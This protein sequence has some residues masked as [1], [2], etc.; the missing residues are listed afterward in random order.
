MAWRAACDRAEAGRTARPVELAKQLAERRQAQTEEEIRS[1]TEAFRDN[2][3]A[4]RQSNHGKAQDGGTNKE[5]PEVPVNGKRSQTPVPPMLPRVLVDPQ[6]LELINPEG[7][8][9]EGSDGGGGGKAKGKKLMEPSKKGKSPSNRVSYR[10]YTDLDRETV[11][12]DLFK[13]LFGSDREDMTDLRTQRG[14]GADAID[15]LRRF[16]ELKVHAGAEPD[17][18]KLT[19]AEV[20]RALSTDD[21]FLVVVSDVEGADAVPRSE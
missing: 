16:F 7:R 3:A 5:L 17:Q 19:N 11:G 4:R 20:R 12:M 18:V 21:Y 14:V 6:D 2:T 15:D 8:I 9:E 10:A 1:R 13:K